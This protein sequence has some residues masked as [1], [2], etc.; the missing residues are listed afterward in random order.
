MLY[1]KF[2]KKIHILIFKCGTLMVRLLI[3]NIFYHIW[4]M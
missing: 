1:L 2:C 4:T 3:I